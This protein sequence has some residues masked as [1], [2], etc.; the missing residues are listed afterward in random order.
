MMTRKLTHLSIYLYS[1]GQTM[2]CVG[3][4]LVLPPVIFSFSLDSINY[5]LDFDAVLNPKLKSSV[6]SYEWKDYLNHLVAM[7]GL[8]VNNNQISY[9]VHSNSV[10]L[11]K[12]IDRVFV[13]LPALP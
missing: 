1:L 11:Y 13:L 10:A 5:G 6:C 4:L 9:Y 3:L 7:G 2:S 12:H 8:R